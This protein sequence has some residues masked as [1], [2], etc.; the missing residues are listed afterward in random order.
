MCSWKSTPIRYG[1]DV[2]E[3]G[4]PPEVSAKTV[5]DPSGNACRILAPVGEEDLRHQPSFRRFPGLHR[6]P[7]HSRLSISSTGNNKIYAASSAQKTTLDLGWRSRVVLS[8]GFRRSPTFAPKH[9]HG[10]GGLNGR[11]RNGN[12]C[13]P[14]GMVAGKAA[15]RRSGRAGRGVSAQWLVT[16]PKGTHHQ[17]ASGTLGNGPF[18]RS[19]NETHAATG[20]EP[21]GVVKLL[22]C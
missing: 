12:G 1:I 9:Y 7:S 14:A 11:V 17:G 10:P 16:T 15:R 4:I 19:V 21:I 20:G 13:G 8:G 3:N 2:E 18:V 22:G 5:V 6:R